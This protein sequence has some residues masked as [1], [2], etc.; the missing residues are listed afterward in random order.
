MQVKGSSGSDIHETEYCHNLIAQVHPN[1]SED[2]EYKIMHAM[3]IAR[4]MDDINNTVITHGASFT[5]Q[6]LL[7]T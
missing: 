2:V 6:F 3:Q 4:C 7:H 5:K 1:P